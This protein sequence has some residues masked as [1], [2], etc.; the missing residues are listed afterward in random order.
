MIENRSMV[1]SYQPWET[2]SFAYT[3]QRHK[4]EMTQAICK[5][6]SVKLCLYDLTGFD[7]PEG[8]QGWSP[9]ACYFNRAF[10]PL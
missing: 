1:S 7:C 5:I 8:F 9:Y 3:F 10:G 4:Q 6:N 2:V